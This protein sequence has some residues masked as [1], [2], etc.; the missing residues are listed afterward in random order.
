MFIPV[1]YKTYVYSFGATVVAIM[2]KILSVLNFLSGL[3]ISFDQTSPFLIALGVVLSLGVAILLW[4]FIGVKLANKLAAKWGEKNIR[5]KPRYAC[6]YFERNPG[7]YEYLA[8]INPRFAEKYVLDG[9]GELM[10]R[11][12]N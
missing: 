12:S 7:S 1:F 11:K 8:S 10:A 3:A 9:K 2:A 5:T 6:E 4:Y